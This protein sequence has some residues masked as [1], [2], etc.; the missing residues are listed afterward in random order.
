MTVRMVSLFPEHL[1]LNGD[2]A[3][4]LVASK[5]LEWFGYE[6][7]VIAVGMGEDI[8]E[9]AHLIFL[10]HGS[11]AAWNYLSVDL[12]RLV[13]QIRN[14]IAQGSGFMAIASGYEKA[15]RLGFFGGD[16]SAKK[17]VSKFEVVNLGN[18]EVL[19]YLNS[20]TKAPVI[21]KDGLSLGSQLHG[22][23]FAKNPEL[24]DSYLAEI[25]AAKKYSVAKKQEKNNLDQVA[26]ITEAVWSLERELARE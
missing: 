3:N 9:D 23:L 2:Q 18:L 14:G 5:R 1:N 21:Q 7:Q 17:R 13:P 20:T 10:G 24:V 15:I 11:L 8:P 22:P 6:S 25:L 12:E 16:L 26:E 19:G 4:L